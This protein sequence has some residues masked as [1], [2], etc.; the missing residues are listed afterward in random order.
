MKKLCLILA[1]ALLLITVFAG[2]DYS[3]ANEATWEQYQEWLIDTFADVTSNP[4]SFENTVNALKSMDDINMN[5]SPWSQIFGEYYYNAS[6]YEE[7]CVL[8]YGTYTDYANAGS[9]TTTAVSSNN[10]SGDMGGT[11][12][13]TAGAS[14]EM[15]GTSAGSAVTATA[16]SQPGGAG[17]A[18]NG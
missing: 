10:A 1:A 14:G 12:T 17:G 11:N 5:S 4:T 13:Q 9:L 16:V 15:G 7:F 18:S 2:C 8:G 6:T 3:S